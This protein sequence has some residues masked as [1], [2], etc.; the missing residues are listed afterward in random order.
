MT[1]P[2]D[3]D[4]WERDEEALR[5]PAPVDPMRSEAARVARYA[6]A[7]HR[8]FI[9][10][11]EG[12]SDDEDK[13]IAR[14]VVA[15]ADEEHQIA[16]AA[17]HELTHGT[18]QGK[19]RAVAAEMWERCQSAH[20]QGCERAQAAEAKV[21]ELRRDA[22]AEALA[23]RAVFAKLQAAE[24]KVKAA[25]ALADEEDARVAAVNERLAQ[26]ETDPKSG[27]PIRIVGTIATRELRA[28]LADTPAE[29]RA[30][31]GA[32]HGLNEHGTT[33]CPVERVRAMADDEDGVLICSACGTAKA[34]A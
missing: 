18:G 34:G 32:G 4:L 5:T 11:S 12:H 28:A 27:K 2:E 25:Y 10:D 30:E 7:I 23:Y 19:A 16:E 33:D 14:A 13:E 24:A 9:P 17:I 15:V 22:F 21:A 26:R 29:Q 8:V 1:T 31:G 20:E 3:R 6:E